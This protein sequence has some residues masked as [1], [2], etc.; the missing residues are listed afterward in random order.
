MVKDG[1]VL[2]GKPHLAAACSSQGGICPRTSTADVA[3][4]EL[5][6]DGGIRRGVGEGKKKADAECLLVLKQVFMV[7][8]AWWRWYFQGESRRKEN[9]ISANSFRFVKQK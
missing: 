6:K 4:F 2:A 3:A 7:D 8:M 9:I 5:V 1:Q